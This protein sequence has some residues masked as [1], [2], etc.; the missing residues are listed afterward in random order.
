MTTLGAV[1]PF[2]E[3]NAWLAMDVPQVRQERGAM[4]A[5]CTVSFD[6]RK[7]SDPTSDRGPSLRH[8]LHRPPPVLPG[9]GKLLFF[10]TF[11]EK[12]FG[13]LGTFFVPRHVTR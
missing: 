11:S 7:Q 6:G 10:K 9:W 12:D 5:S 8:R 4:T 1:S 2:R 13:F 3:K